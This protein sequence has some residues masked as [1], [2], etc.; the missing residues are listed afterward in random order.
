M[1]TIDNPQK[2]NMGKNPR[3]IRNY[4]LQPY[5]Q[6]KLG[7]YTIFLSLM[8]SLAVMLILYSNLGGLTDVVMQLT[9]VPDE[10]NELMAE[11]IAPAKLQIVLV[12]LFYIVINICVTVL[13]THK[14][15]GPTIAFRRHLQM[16]ADGKLQYR[17]VLRSGDAFTELAED[18]NRLSS[19]LEKNSK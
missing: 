9:G 7:L 6:V 18:L 13:Y 1:R 11:Y 16:I 3:S 15:V 8:F 5:L 14:L 12:S 17:T 4:A 19:Q 10:V 2:A